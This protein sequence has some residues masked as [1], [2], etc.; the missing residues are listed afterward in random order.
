MATKQPGALD[1]ATDLFVYQNRSSSTLNGAITAGATAIT[2]TDG[3]QFP[4]SGRF[5]ITI[6]NEIIII[7]SR[8]VNVLTAE[9]RGA[10]G[11]TGVSHADTTDVMMN[12]T[13]GILEA[14]RDAVIATQEGHVRYP[15][16]HSG[17]LGL[18]KY[19]QD[20]FENVRRF[21]L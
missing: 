4:S 7:A 17:Q 3:T 19:G 18:R 9:S 16:A 8:S 12:V 2:V 5:V 13:A 14:V 20:P 15:D 21:C 11:T 6:E 10:E 1:A